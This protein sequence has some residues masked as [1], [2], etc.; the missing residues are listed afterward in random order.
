MS[1]PKWKR[2]RFELK[3]GS[4]YDS[5]PEP[6]GKLKGDIKLSDPTVEVRR[7]TAYEYSPAIP[8]HMPTESLAP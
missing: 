1:L 8:P 2:R 4:L 3:G 5:E 6:G 7:C